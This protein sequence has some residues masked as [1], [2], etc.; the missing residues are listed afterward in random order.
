[1]G[2]RG[3]ALPISGVPYVPR[4][5]GAVLACCTLLCLGLWRATPSASA[6]V[7]G[8]V[9]T[10]HFSQECQTGIGVGITYDGTNL[11]YSCFESSPD[12]FRANPTTGEVTASYTIAE[13]H[14]L[15][16]LAYDATRNAIW[17]GPGGTAPNQIAL[18]KLNSSKEV[19]SHEV[20]FETPDASYLDDG[21]AYDG[22]NDTLYI[23]PDG[24]VAIHHY[25]TAG[26]H[27]G[28][29]GWAGSEC[30]NSG[31]ALGG[32]VLYQGADGCNRIYAAEEANPSGPVL[33]S[34]GTAL[35]GDP[36]FRDEALTCDPKTFASLG[37][38][39]IWS[40]EGLAPMRAAAF[41]IPANSCGIGG[42]ADVEVGTM[43]GLGHVVATSAHPVLNV[44]VLLHCNQTHPPNVLGLLW[45]GHRF[46]LTGLTTAVCT[47]D[48]TVSPRQPRAGFNTYTGAGIG[49]Y[50]GMPGA[51]ATWTLN[52][53][54]WG[55]RDTLSVQVADGGSA[56]LDVSGPLA[57]GAFLALP[58][59]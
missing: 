38:Q 54:G 32:G 11:W 49:T 53:S 30:F 42:L 41:E 14:G 6:A 19:V 9:G 5:L 2:T 33:F 57:T 10:V 51:T 44:S 56:V 29:A 26:N 55:A 22:S 36:N 25:D 40:K 46:Q 4:I 1:M 59:G 17:A 28:D 23:S 35:E 43:T 47:F 18:I 39:V 21:L 16:A 37:K 34:F 50:D 15:G 58:S 8:L 13:G 24:S 45:G 7:G 12:L 27:L 52:D 3:T 31:I 48:P 20:K